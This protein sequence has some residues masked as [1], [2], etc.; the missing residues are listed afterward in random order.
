MLG[1]F[2]LAHVAYILLF[3]RRLRVRRLPLWTI[4]YALWWLLMMMVL[5]PH[6]GSLIL[7]VGA[8]GI[9]LAGTAATSA[10]CRAAIAWGE[11]PS[12][13]PATRSSRSA[14]SSLTPCPTGRAR[15]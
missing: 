8:Y 9:V 12:S 11:A 4:V 1:F 15:P 14:C 3:L 7:A 10:R 2:G 13:S 5:G 6:T